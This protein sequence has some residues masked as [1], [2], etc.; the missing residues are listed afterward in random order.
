MFIIKQQRN[1]AA[2]ENIADSIGRKADYYYATLRQLI[3]TD[4][5]F[6]RTPDHKMCV[7]MNLKACN[8]CNRETLTFMRKNFRDK[9]ICVYLDQKYTKDDISLPGIQHLQVRY[10]E[11]TPFF[12]SVNPFFFLNINGNNVLKFSHEASY[13]EITNLYFDNIKKYF[14][15]DRY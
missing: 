2:K 3:E 7:Y 6:I 8:E 13:P 11:R 5:S 10:I 4:T 14:H 9:D 1:T 15:D 12:N